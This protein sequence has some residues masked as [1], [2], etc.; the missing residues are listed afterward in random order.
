MSHVPYRIDGAGFQQWAFIPYRGQWPAFRL[1]VATSMD[2]ELRIR[3]IN[4][5][6]YS[7]ILPRSNLTRRVVTARTCF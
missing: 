5:I 1:M 4:E 7:L 6:M 3:P 2:L